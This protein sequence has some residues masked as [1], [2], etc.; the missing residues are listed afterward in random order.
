MVEGARSSLSDLLM[1]EL[2]QEPGV[3][4]DDLREAS[5]Y[6]ALLHDG[7]RLLGNPP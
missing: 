6:V 2:D 3:P 5:S 1:F 4:L 7:L